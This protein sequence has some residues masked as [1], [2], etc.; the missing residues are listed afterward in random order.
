[1]KYSKIGYFLILSIILALLGLLS[2]APA[3]AAIKSIYLQ[4]REGRI[5][6]WIGVNVYNFGA[7][8][9]VDIYFSS[10]EAGKDDTIGR[11]VTAYQHVMEAST[12]GDGSFGDL[13]FFIVPDR[14]TDGEHE[15]DVHGGD[16]YV[17]ATYPPSTTIVCVATFTVMGGEIELDPEEGAVGSEVEISGEGL[18]QS[19]KIS[20]EYDDDKVDIMRGDSETDSKGQFVGA[21]VIPESIVGEH[22]IAV[23]DESGDRPEAEFSVKTK[24]T[25]DLGEQAIG[26][27]VAVRGTGF[28]EDEAITLTIALLTIDTTPPSLVTDHLGSFS[29]S[30]VVPFLDSC[31]LKSVGADDGN[32]VR[33]ADAQL[34]VL[35]GIALSPTSP[36]SPGYVGMG[37][38]AGADVV[39]TYAIDDEAIP[40]ATA[41]TDDNGK[42][43]VRFTVPPS[44]A[45]SHTVTVT[46]GI[47][48]ATSTFTMEAQAPLM[49]R[50]LLPEI[51]STSPAEAYFDWEDV[52][53]PSGVSY[54]LQVA[55]DANFANI[56]LEGEGLPR[57]EYAMGEGEKLASTKADAPYY[58][59]VR[60]VDGASNEGDWSP[61]GLFYVGFPWL[62]DWVWYVFGILGVLLLAIVVFRWRGRRSG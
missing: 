19:Q 12:F 35:A 32:G 46:D 5:G 40:V 49:P 37:F 20:V 25:L 11:Q 52:T 10:D 21:I 59:R 48:S 60:A 50:L 1:M 58:W 28:P 8:K 26:G 22:T 17:Y 3:H 41:K 6:D 54:T 27:V 2:P 36:A 9:V 14:L 18:R 16:Y 43:S 7:S 29:C 56:V 45:G 57:S 61:S 39:V 34:T 55:T 15:E 38:S 30:F 44:I 31:G 23:I 53:D 62:S 47:T 51:G 13:L 42:L 24:I 4:P 33:L